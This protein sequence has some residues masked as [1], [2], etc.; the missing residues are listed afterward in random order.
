MLGYDLYTKCHLF[1]TAETTWRNDIIELFCLM[2]SVAIFVSIDAR[3]KYISILFSIHWFENGIFFLCGEFFTFNTI[4]S[5]KEKE[6]GK[7]EKRM[8]QLNSAMHR[9]CCTYCVPY[10]STL[11]CINVVCA[12]KHCIS[13]RTLANP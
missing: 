9:Y 10:D 4:R 8:H 5:F 2:F 3:T 6:R 12:S 7:G 13:V 1:T 11:N